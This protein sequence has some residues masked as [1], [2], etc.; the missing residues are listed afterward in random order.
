MCEYYN[1]NNNGIINNVY[2]INNI[3]SNIN[4]K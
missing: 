2:Y 1:D 4:E 3:E